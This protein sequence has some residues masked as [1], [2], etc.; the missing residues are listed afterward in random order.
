M[1]TF[2][3]ARIVSFVFKKHLAHIVG[4]MES[5]IGC[6]EILEIHPLKQVNTR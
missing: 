3:S 4:F 1:E 5:I 6:F 2:E